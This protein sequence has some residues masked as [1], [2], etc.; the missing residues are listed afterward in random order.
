MNI[1]KRALF[2]PYNYLLRHA[3]SKL[4]KF[5][6]DKEHGSGKWDFIDD[7][8]GDC[9]YLYLEKY[10]AN[11]AILD[12]GCGPGNTAN[13]LA[14]TAYRA[15]VGVDISSVTLRK[16]RERSQ[17]CNRAD[18]NRFVNSDILSYQPTENFN[19][20]LF[21]E[22]IYHV[23]IGKVKPLFQRLS[24][25]LTENGVFIVRIKSADRYSLRQRLRILEDMLDVVESGDHHNRSTVFVFRPKEPMEAI[26]S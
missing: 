23:S 25:C 18:K 19:V 1:V 24:S 17:K 8:Q 14:T 3:P 13:E 6:W 4:K 7:T 11:G 26:E 21:R 10:S 15:Y 12:L 9:V 2:T 22:S 5:C 20:I 16:A